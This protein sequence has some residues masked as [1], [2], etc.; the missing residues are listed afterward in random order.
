MDFWVKVCLVGI[1]ETWNRSCKHGARETCH[2]SW[3]SSFTRIGVKWTREYVR[4]SRIKCYWTAEMD[5][6]TTSVKH[7]S[8]RN[9]RT[10]NH[11]SG[12]GNPWF[13]DWRHITLPSDCGNGRHW[14][15]ANKR[16]TYLDATMSGHNVN[17]QSVR[18]EKRKQ[19]FDAHQLL[20]TSWLY[21]WP[22][23]QYRWPTT[24]I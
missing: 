14:H 18:Y 19:R 20:E 8:Y 10:S 12:F 5:T 7:E 23:C 4:G 6:G 17:H 1:T 13:L 22:S 9:K 24:R 2:K 11:A 15:T 3:H 16:W 21:S